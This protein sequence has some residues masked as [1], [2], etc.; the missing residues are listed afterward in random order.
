MAWLLFVV[1]CS[2]WMFA[3]IVG[4]A[5]CCLLM[6]AVFDVVCLFLFVCCW[7]SLLLVAVC[8]GC[9]LSADVACCILF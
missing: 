8:S 2:W 5:F 6:A 9:L 1:G 4:V 7:C 3:L